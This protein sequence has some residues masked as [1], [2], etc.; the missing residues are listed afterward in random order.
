MSTVTTPATTTTSAVTRT[1]VPA[2]TSALQNSLT[3][4]RRNL[5]HAR[6]YPAMTISLVSMPIAML[7]LFNYVFGGTMSAG[8]DGT[9]GQGSGDYIDYLVPGILLMAVGSGVL[10]TTVGVCTDM[11]EGIVARF[12][13]MPINGSSIL[14]GR[15]VGAV[16]QTMLTIVF[17]IGVAFLIGFR[18]GAEPI[19]WAASAGLLMLMS[20]ALTW[21]AVALGQLVKAPEA[22]S[23]VALPF[24]FLLPFL[25]S[26]FVPLDSMPGWLRHFAE[27]QPYT[28]FTE[29]LRGLL[30]G[31]EIGRFGPLA[32]G[33]GVAIALLGFLWAR[34]LFKRGATR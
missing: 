16:I 28:A 15:A 8:M 6:R 12:R 5:R 17:V 24:S 1:H 20:T 23:S 29:T 33:W 25:S 3:M 10:P 32:V 21:L 34:S 19:E 26:V 7:L 22:A 30:T 9:G 31:T 18:S 13:T 2:P 4:L 27:W 11:T 14:T